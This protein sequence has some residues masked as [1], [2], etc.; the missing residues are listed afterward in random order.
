MATSKSL[1]RIISF[2]IPR[3]PVET[4][5]PTNETNLTHFS[6]LIIDSNM[7]KP[8]AMF[9]DS[10]PPDS[11]ISSKIP[12]IVVFLDMLMSDTGPPWFIM[13]TSN[14]YGYKIIMYAKYVLHNF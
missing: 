13:I 6:S 5:A 11:A 14:L 2:I 4:S 1:R 8:S 10:N 12:L 9:T 3:S 7:S